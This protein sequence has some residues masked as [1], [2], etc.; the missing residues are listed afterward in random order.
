MTPVQAKKIPDTLALAQ[1]YNNRAMEFLMQDNYPE[2]IRYMAAALDIEPGV[3]Y[4]W[5]NL[6]AVYRRSSRLEAAVRAN[7]RW[8]T[9]WLC[10]M[11]LRTWWLSV[12]LPGFMISWVNGKRH[13]P[14]TIKR[15][16]SVK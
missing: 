11:I 15:S 5:S 1:H 10:S 14:Y 3:S 2:A 13:K 9:V 6:G 16:T 4:F 12:V 7:R 8:H